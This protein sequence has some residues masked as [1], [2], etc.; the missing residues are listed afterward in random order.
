MNAL[1]VIIHCVT[2]RIIQAEEQPLL[3]C[4]RLIILVTKFKADL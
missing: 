4:P 3:D 2:F 1:H